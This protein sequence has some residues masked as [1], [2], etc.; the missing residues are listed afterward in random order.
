MLHLV[1]IVELPNQAPQVVVELANTEAYEGTVG[2]FKCKFQGQPEPQVKWYVFYFGDC[3][4]LDI[5]AMRDGD[6]LLIHI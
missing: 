6:L 1:A 4:V 3:L 5:I 2:R